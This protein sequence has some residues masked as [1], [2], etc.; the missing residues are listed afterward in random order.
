MAARCG[1]A[2]LPSFSRRFK[3]HFGQGPGAYRRARRTG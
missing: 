1:Y 3:F 2:S